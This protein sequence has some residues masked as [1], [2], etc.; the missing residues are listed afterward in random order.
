MLDS[1]GM[2]PMAGEDSEHSSASDC[3]GPGSAGE[4]VCGR[5]VYARGKCQSHY[6]Q[7]KAGE[8]LR[9]LAP[10]R[11]FRRNV[12]DSER[13]VRKYG[14]SWPSAE[15]LAQ[16]EDYAIAEGISPTDMVVRL[17][18]ERLDSLAKEGRSR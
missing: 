2:V 7:E 10:R 1:V 17:V 4:P 8:T 18:G 5:P 15:R 13:P 9:P 6:L 16:L 11:A 14:L 3:D 12:P